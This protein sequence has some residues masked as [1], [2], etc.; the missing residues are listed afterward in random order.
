[1]ALIIDFTTPDPI[2]G[3]EDAGG[4]GLHY[5]HFAILLFIFTLIVI[6]VISFCTE[7]WPDDA[8]SFGF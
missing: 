2:C 6:I 5:L 1:M 8:V 3:V 7:S 4:G